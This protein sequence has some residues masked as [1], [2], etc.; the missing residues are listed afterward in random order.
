MRAKLGEP[1]C[2][3]CKY[4]VQHYYKLEGLKNPFIKVNC[5]HCIY[6]RLKKCEPC[7]AVCEH[8][9]RAELSEGLLKIK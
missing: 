5:G 7:S 2:E 3:T 4:F 6:P 9:E 1:A 8:Y